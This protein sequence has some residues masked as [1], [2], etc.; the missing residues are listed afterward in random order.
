MSP[1][2]LAAIYALLS[3]HVAPAGKGLWK[4]FKSPVRIVVSVRWWKEMAAAAD[5]AAGLVG[6]RRVLSGSR[7]PIRVPKLV[8]FPEEGPLSWCPDKSPAYKGCPERESNPHD[9]AVNGV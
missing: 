8:P 5:Q 3:S 9:L 4:G 2:K 7:E 1:L 6:R